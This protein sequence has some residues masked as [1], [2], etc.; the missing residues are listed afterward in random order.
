MRHQHT[1]SPVM[2]A[3]PATRTP[4]LHTR[5]GRF[6][7]WVG[8]VILPIFWVW[9]MRPPYFIDTQRRAGWCWTWIHLNLLLMLFH[10]PLGERA[11]SA[12][13]GWEWVL[14]WITLVLWLWLA[15][16]L[17]RLDHL[18]FIYLMMGEVVA[19]ML[20]LY[21]PFLRHMP[22]ALITILALLFFTPVLPAALH[23]LVVP[24][25]EW[26]QQR[27]GRMAEA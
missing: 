11:L 17:F 16:R 2:N 12:L 20:H 27:R 4:G 25:R 1:R 3:M 23:L 14:G 24:A 8:L 18:F 19:P 9:W 10:Q 13:Y 6:F 5:R 15:L 22:Q 26:W 7:F 21:L